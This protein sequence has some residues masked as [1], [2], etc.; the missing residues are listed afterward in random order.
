M[1]STPLRAAP[2]AW[3]HHLGAWGLQAVGSLIRCEMAVSAEGRRASATPTAAT[4]EGEGFAVTGVARLLGRA[5]DSTVQHEIW[6]DIAELLLQILQRS[7][8]HTHLFGTLAAKPATAVSRIRQVFMR[9]R[10]VGDVAGD[11]I[12]RISIERLCGRPGPLSALA[13]IKTIHS[14]QARVVL[15]RVCGNIEDSSYEIIHLSAHKHQE[16]Q[17]YEG[18]APF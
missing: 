8:V 16:K 9:V 17:A 2:L 15:I 12:A 3:N 5:I 6:T 7:A 4:P 1:Q 10:G 13:A 11:V 14:Q 18:S